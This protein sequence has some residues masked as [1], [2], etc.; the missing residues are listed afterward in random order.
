MLLQG[1]VGKNHH[2]GQTIGG[3]GGGGS[4]CLKKVGLW[5]LLNEYLEGRAHDC[6]KY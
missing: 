3:G 1:H 6:L 4:G 5:I 2:S